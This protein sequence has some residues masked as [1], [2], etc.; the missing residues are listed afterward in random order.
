M[1]LLGLLGSLIAVCYLFSKS[2]II[3]FTKNNSIQIIS[4]KVDTLSSAE[5]FSIILIEWFYDI[6]YIKST[7]TKCPKLKYLDQTPLN[8]MIWN[9]MSKNAISVNAIYK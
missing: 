9:G 6:W 4:R 3:L 1:C 7:Y 5:L 2:N 8:K